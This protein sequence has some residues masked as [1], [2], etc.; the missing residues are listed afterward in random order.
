MLIIG[1]S[2]SRK[3]NVLLN[4]TIEQDSDNLVANIYLYAKDL[5]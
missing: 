4:I 5:N 3:T 1:D 2:R